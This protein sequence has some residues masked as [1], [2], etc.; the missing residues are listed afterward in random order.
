MIRQ[1]LRGG[2]ETQSE[3]P[4]VAPPLASVTPNSSAVSACSMASG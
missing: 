3:T 1:I 4:G 2:R